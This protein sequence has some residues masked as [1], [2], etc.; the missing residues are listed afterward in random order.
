MYHHNNYPIT[1]NT[2]G[3]GFNPD[4]PDP[5]GKHKHDLMP[6]AADLAKSAHAQNIERW[7]KTLEN[8]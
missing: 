8:N 1:L 5:T 3:Y 7:L 4:L 6:A 2:L